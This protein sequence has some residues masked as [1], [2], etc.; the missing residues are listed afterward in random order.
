MI[1]TRYKR[2]DSTHGQPISLLPGL[3]CPIVPLIPDRPLLLKQ[4][5]ILF[6]DLIGGSVHDEDFRACIKLFSR[7]RILVD[8]VHDHDRMSSSVK[9]RS[10][11]EVL[12]SP[13]RLGHGIRQVIEVAL[14]G[15]EFGI[16]GIREVL[17]VIHEYRIPLRIEPVLQ[18]LLELAGV[19]LIPVVKWSFCLPL[20]VI[21]DHI[22]PIYFDGVEV[23]HLDQAL[24][25]LA[26]RHFL[27]D[28]RILARSQ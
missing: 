19:E 28:C 20:I 27:I 5:L 14:R 18:G 26:H 3:P 25:G 24:L 21:R 11:D 13:I 10:P 6:A 9:P 12:E 16:K 7:F 2:G 4:V 1:T 15:K 22:A 23:R 17:G 8:S